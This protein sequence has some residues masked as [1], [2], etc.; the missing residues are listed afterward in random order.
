MSIFFVLQCQKTL[1]G[2]H[3]ELRFEKFPVANKFVDE[4]DARVY[5]SFLSKR[6]GLTVR[7]KFVGE[8]SRVSLI[9]GIEKF[10]A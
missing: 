10:Y 4:E 9:S 7:K 8:P 3:S 6:F 1:Q 2:N 5:Q